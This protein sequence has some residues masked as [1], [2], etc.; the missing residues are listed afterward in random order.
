MDKETAKIMIQSKSVG[1]GIILAV[2]FGALGLLYASIKG[3]VIM[4]FVEII[5]ILLSIATLGLGAIILMPAC[6]IACAIWANSAIK[7][8]NAALFA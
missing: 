2:I 7:N 1:L 6:H 8:H 5:C 3:G 4:M